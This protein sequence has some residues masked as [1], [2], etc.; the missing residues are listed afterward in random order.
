MSI[1]YG[2]DRGSLDKMVHM[3]KDVSLDKDDCLV[4][5]VPHRV[6]GIYISHC[7]THFV[8]VNDVNCVHFRCTCM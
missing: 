6:A 2:D 7:G 3:D 8:L 1:K 5:V 4:E